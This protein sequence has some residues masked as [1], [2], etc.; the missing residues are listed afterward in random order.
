MVILQPKH[1]EIYDSIHKAFLF[2]YTQFCLGL[3][4]VQLQM[5][6]QFEMD[7]PHS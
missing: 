7:F 4:Q 2:S 5:L 1:F 6:D 3:F